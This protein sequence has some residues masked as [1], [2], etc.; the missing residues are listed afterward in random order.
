M[1]ECA[2]GILANKWRTFHRP[3]DV[4]LQFCGSTAKACCI[5]HNFVRRNDGFQLEGSLYDCNIESIQATYTWTRGNT[6]GNHVTDY[7]TT[8]RCALAVRYSM[9]WN[10][11]HP[12]KVF[13]FVPLL[14]ATRKS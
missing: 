8:R 12:E 14:T 2:F 9:M 5:L 4:T 3:L 1:V 13:T 6:K 10:L 7:V 11:T